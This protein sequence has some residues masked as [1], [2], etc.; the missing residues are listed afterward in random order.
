MTVDISFCGKKRVLSEMSIDEALKS[1]FGDKLPESLDLSKETDNNIYCIAHQILIENPN[2]QT[3]KRQHSIDAEIN[4]PVESQRIISE[5][6]QKSVFGDD[7]AGQP[8]SLNDL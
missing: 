5:V 6:V 8:Q 7:G 1:V 3:L 4:E 2:D